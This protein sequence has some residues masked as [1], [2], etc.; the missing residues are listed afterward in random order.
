MTL[1]AGYSSFAY[2]ALA[3]YKMGML[4]SAFFQR[5]RLLRFNRQADATHQVGEARVGTDVVERWSIA[6]EHR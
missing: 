5:R 6:E 2:S 4:G 1:R 3:F